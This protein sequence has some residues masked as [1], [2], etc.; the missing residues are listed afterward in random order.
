LFSLEPANPLR[1]TVYPL[2]NCLKLK[3]KCKLQ[4]VDY[5]LQDEEQFR[6]EFAFFNFHFS[7]KFSPSFQ[8][9]NGYLYGW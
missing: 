1:R 2:Q 3:A 9:L 6:V 4:N 8:G 7:M 5:K